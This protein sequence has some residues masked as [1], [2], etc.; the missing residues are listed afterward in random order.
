MKSYKLYL[1]TCL[2]PLLLISCGSSD[3]D[4]EPKIPN[5][6]QPSPSNGDNTGGNGNN[7]NSG[8]NSGNDNQGIEDVHDGYSDQPAYSK[9]Y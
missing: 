3:D 1:I 7:E 8:N 9:R 2:V 6:E 4:N 5:Q